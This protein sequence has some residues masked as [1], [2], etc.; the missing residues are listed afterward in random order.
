[1][2]RPKPGSGSVLAAG[3]AARPL[4]G[5]SRRALSAPAGPLGLQGHFSALCCSS[6][7]LWLEGFVRSHVRGGFQALLLLVRCWGTKVALSKARG[8][9]D[10]RG[11]WVVSWHLWGLAAR[12][13][14][15][16]CLRMFLPP[17]AGGYSAGRQGWWRGAVPASSCLY[18]LRGRITGGA[19]RGIFRVA[20][21]RDPLPWL[22]WS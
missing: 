9:R 22:V 12:G 21:P 8:R 6:Y 2:S 4:P 3:S 20:A 15:A 19:S 13:S 17:A 10:P 11:C 14:Q 16:A 5:G 1:M 18:P 7:E